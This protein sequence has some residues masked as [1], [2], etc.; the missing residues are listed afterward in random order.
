MGSENILFI[1]EA[2]RKIFKTEEHPDVATTINNIAN[3]YGDLGDSEKA[4][5]M[6]E[7]NFGKKEAGNN[8]YLHQLK[9]FSI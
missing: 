2:R 4:L 6:H 5:R 3:F 1:M 9:Y 7:Q 8:Y